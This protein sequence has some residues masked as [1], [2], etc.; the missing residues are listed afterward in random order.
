LQNTVTSEA[1]DVRSCQ[2]RRLH[3]NGALSQGHSTHTARNLRRRR[4]VR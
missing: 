3:G 1:D 4:E 2:S